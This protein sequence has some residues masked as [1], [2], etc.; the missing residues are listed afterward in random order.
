MEF[1]IATFLIAVVLILLLAPIVMKLFTSLRTPVSEQLGNLTGT[2]GISGTKDAQTS[3]NF[4]IGTGVSLWDEITVMVFF[5]M[6]IV[7]IVSSI[8]I[9]TNPVFIFLYIIMAFL[10][11][12]L[13]PNII[14]A[15]DAV[16]ISPQLADQFGTPASQQM[17]FIYYLI[18][19]FGE[20]FLGIMVFTG[21][22][23]YSKIK[24]FGSGG[25]RT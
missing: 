21:I 17:P 8:F 5:F 25:Q 11:I 20:F 1:P 19:H 14:N 24:F 23:I 6:V 7:L 16:Y 9:D 4:I 15:L 3:W 12:I 10:L 22:I 18:Q 2:T 13:A